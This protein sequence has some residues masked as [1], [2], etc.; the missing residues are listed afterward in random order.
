MILAI[1]VGQAI[2]HMRLGL[3]QED[4]NFKP[5]LLESTPV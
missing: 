1:V 4:K 5:T 2:E 3:H